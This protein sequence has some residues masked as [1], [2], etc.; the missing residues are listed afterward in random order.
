MDRISRYHVRGPSAFLNWQRGSNAGAVD[1]SLFVFSR[2]TR[3]NSRQECSDD[4]VD[5]RPHFLSVATHGHEGAAE[6]LA[7]VAAF[8][9]DRKCPTASP[10]STSIPAP[11]LFQDP[12]HRRDAERRRRAASLRLERVLVVPLP[13][14]AASHIERRYLVVPGLRSSRIHILDTKPDPRRPASSR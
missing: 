9:P 2:S 14:R 10:S 13:Q 11:Q 7:Y 4:N 1:M 3:T 5:A 6:T 12:Q 8:D